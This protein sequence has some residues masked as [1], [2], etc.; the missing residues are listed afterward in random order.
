MKD[1]NAQMLE[2][3]YRVVDNKAYLTIAEAAKL[4]GVTPSALR[5]HTQRNV[6]AMIRMLEVNGKDIM[7]LDAETMAQETKYYAKKGNEG[8]VK[9]AIATLEAGMNVYIYG[10][11]GVALPKPVPRVPTALE[12]ARANI[13][14]AKETVQM[15]EDL[16]A[17]SIQAD[18]D[19]IITNKSDEYYP[20]SHVRKLNTIVK[21]ELSKLKSVSDEL[22]FP[23]KKLYGNYEAG[24]VNTYHKEVWLEIYPDILL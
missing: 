23:P 1:L 6:R 5:S 24:K 14:K 8:A 9:L 2:N 11:A 15:L 7:H 3:E 4:L 20:V 16:E 19:A 10:S 17:L 18:E 21:L 13:I 22:G 12:L